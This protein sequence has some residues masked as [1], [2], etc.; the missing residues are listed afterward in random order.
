V[1]SSVSASYLQLGHE[2]R[3]AGMVAGAR[4]GRVLTDVDVPILAKSLLA[5][6]VYAMVLASQETNASVMVYSADSRTLP[7]FLWATLENAGNA[8]TA[9][10][11]ALVSMT[12]TGSLLIVSWLVSRWV[13][14]SWSSPSAESVADPG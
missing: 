11:I 1:Y 5:A 14:P 12:M 7:V 13:Q 10:V 4:I 6:F 2:L 9:A 8:T 3:E